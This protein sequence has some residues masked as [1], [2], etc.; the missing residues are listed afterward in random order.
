MKRRKAMKEEE[1]VYSAVT[2]GSQNRRFCKMPAIPPRQFKPQVSLSRRSFILNNGQKWVNGTVLHYYFFTKPEEW[3]TNDREKNVVRQ[4]FAKWKQLSIGLE[5]QEVA[6]P[7]DAEIR[8]GFLR[9]DGAWSYVGREILNI[10]RD[11]RTMNFG[12]DLTVPAD[13][14]Q[15]NDIDTATHEIGHALG[16]EHEHQNPKAGIVWDEEAVYASLAQP[17]NSWSREE[18]FENII[19]KLSSREVAGSDWDPN[20]I[21]EYPFDAGLI[22][23]PA[24]FR[25]G[26]QPAGGLSQFDIAWVKTNYPPQDE[27]NFHKLELRQSVDMNIPAG[28]QKDFIIIPPETRKYNIQ[29]FGLSDSVMTLFEEVGGKMVYLFGR[30]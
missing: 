21:M 2:G 28:M 6:S 17:P 15:P 20:S 7:D 26:L 19:K 11:E 14:S 9:D 27:R 8:I 30:G 29:T 24:Q 18:T 16:L 25:R 1:K 3:T 22:K 5:F 12:W 23:E 4:A 10:G 13:D